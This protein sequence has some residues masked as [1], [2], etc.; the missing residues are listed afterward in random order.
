MTV[1]TRSPGYGRGHDALIRATVTV[2]ARRG[3]RG[4][5]FRAVADEAGVRNTLITYHF[6]TREQMLREAVRWAVAESIGRSLPLTRQ[7]I[8]HDFARA[9]TELV[10]T[11]PDLQT[12]H[13]EILI[14]SRRNPALRELAQLLVDDYLEG[15]ERILRQRGHRHPKRLARL[16]HATID[17]LVFQQLTTP[18]ADGLEPALEQ[19]IEML[20]ADLRNNAL[21]ER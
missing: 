19:F 7:D 2:V 12:F 8:D 17:G 11:D 21:Q 20:N 18:A 3:L 16:A 9:M 10:R 14:E 5:T 13:Y 1:S 4:T 15:L 6:G